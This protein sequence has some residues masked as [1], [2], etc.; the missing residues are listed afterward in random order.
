MSPL[1]QTKYEEESMCLCYVVPQS[2][3]CR[4]SFTERRNECP[5]LAPPSC[6][7]HE[8]WSAV[9][10]PSAVIYGRWLVPLQST[11]YAML[12][13]HERSQMIGA[14][15]A[16]QSKDR[17]FRHLSRKSPSTFPGSYG[18]VNYR[19]QCE[20]STFALNARAARGRASLNELSRVCPA[21][22]GCA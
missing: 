21:Q 22:L 15:E 1:C 6:I 14:L 16:C 2:V 13:I 7:V 17:D 9:R 12:G 8:S 5:L 11:F 10:F 20:Q 3:A 4:D 19:K 18:C